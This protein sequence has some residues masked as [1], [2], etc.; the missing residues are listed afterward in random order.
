MTGTTEPKT[1]LGGACQE[2]WVFSRALPV[3]LL[4]LVSASSNRLMRSAVA[5]SR[6]RASEDFQHG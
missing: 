2:D 4:G 6:F 1:A 5:G 3:P